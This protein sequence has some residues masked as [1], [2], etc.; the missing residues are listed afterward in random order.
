[1]CKQ[2]IKKQF[3]NV[4]ALPQGYLLSRALGNCLQI[5][6]PQITVHNFEP[7]EELSE[8]C[9]SAEK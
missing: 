3:C 4:E 2:V 1:M 9:A 5:S 7:L 6:R 8:K